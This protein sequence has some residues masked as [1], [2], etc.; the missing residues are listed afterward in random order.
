METHICI[1]GQW[2]YVAIAQV[3]GRCIEDSKKRRGRELLA[4]C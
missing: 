2:K 4:L 3:V 1:H